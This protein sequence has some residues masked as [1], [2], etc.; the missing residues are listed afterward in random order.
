MCDVFRCSALYG[1]RWRPN[2]AREGRREDGEGVK[3]RLGGRWE[4]EEEKEE[5]RKWERGGTEGGGGAL[6][7]GVKERSA[8]AAPA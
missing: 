6:T 5:G 3:D 4:E 8:A 7:E 1:E 2:T